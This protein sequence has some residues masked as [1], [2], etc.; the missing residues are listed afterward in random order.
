MATGT[1][2]PYGGLPCSSY[3]TVS[4]STAIY[5]SGTG[6]GGN[7]QNLDP[8]VY[9]DPQT[10][11]LAA[12]LNALTALPHIPEHIAKLLEKEPD[13][14]QICNCPGCS[15]R[16]LVATGRLTELIQSIEFLCKENEGLKK[17]IDTRKTVPFGRH[18]FLDTVRELKDQLTSLLP[19]KETAQ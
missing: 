9:T 15:A 19:T 14:T 4:L 8:E 10:K 12:V 3:A 6:L 18:T 17:T 7:I 13:P 11:S 1:F 16:R 2:N 5:T